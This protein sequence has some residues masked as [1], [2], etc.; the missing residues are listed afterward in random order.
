MWR[1][2]LPLVLILGLVVGAP[3][4][5]AMAQETTAVIVLELEPQA[6]APV[7]TSAP[8]AVPSTAA[9]LIAGRLVSAGKSVFYDQVLPGLTILLTGFM[10][11][12]WSW[13][14][15]QMSLRIQLDMEKRARDVISSAVKAIEERCKAQESEATVTDKLA[16]VVEH[17]LESFPKLARSWIEREALA[18]VQSDP[19]MGSTATA[20]AASKE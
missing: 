15:A 4:S 2:L 1:S 13:L 14:R 7:A 20:K 16:W 12:L 18:V 3:V 17:V 5:P 9:K 10:L 6:S 19:E 11:N 8:R